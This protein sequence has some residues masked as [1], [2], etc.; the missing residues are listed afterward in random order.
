MVAEMQ[1]LVDKVWRHCE[2]TGNRGR[3]I[4]LKIKFA[5]FEIA[6]RS[7]SVPAPVQ[8]RDDFERLARTS[9]FRIDKAM[10]SLPFVAS[11]GR[12]TGY[13]PG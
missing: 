8:S 11:A 3:T 6:T 12:F 9:F 2:A 1:P 10:S 4:T 13:D 7:R 5:D